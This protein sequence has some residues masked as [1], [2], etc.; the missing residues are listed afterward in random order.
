[1]SDLPKRILLIS[2]ITVT[3]ALPLF[4]VPLPV[5]WSA[6]ALL[7]WSSA[8]CGYSGITLLLWMYILGAKSISRFLT[9][10]LATSLAI[11]KYLGIY[12]TLLIFAH[13]VLVTIGYG[14]SWQYWFIPQFTTLAE[15]HIMLGQV[16]LWA[17]VVLWVSSAVVRGKLSWRTWRYLHWLAYLAIPFALLHVP[18]LGAQVQTHFWIKAY[19]FTLMIIYILI[20]I[21]RLRSWLNLDKLPYK[22]MSRTELTG[23][24]TLL[25]LSPAGQ[26]RLVPRRGQY[27]YVKLGFISEDHPFSVVQY[28]KK[29]GEI[30]LGVRCAG[31]YSKEIEALAEGDFVLLGGPYGEFTDSI[32]QAPSTP[33]VYIAGG[34][35]VTPFVDRIMSESSHRE[36]WLFTA[37][38]NRELAVL[39]AP[40]KE[41]LGSHAVTVFS[42]GSHELLPGEA[43]GHITAELLRKY[44]DN[45]THYTYYLCGPAAMMSTA[46]S[47]IISLGV[48]AS[49][50]FSEKFGW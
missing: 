48:P 43:H 31:M 5:M 12:G 45:P 38:R 50:I 6:S 39:Y 11:H 13:P 34:I 25:K 9:T 8:I 4:I 3:V 46:R 37:H 47:A 40:L 35:G 41:R 14:E 26:H 21:L 42:Q 17:L 29:S 28:D 49:H 23:L 33:V 15:R 19:L 44:L 10:D 18:D 30:T 2:A 36:Q 1:M 24:D 16:A 20:S 27:V 32:D 7:L 22:V